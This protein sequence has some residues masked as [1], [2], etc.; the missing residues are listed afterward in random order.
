MSNP[1]R[2]RL[3]GLWE[4]AGMLHPTRGVPVP[5]PEGSLNASV[6]EFFRFFEDGTFLFGRFLA[7]AE[8]SF[9][10]ARRRFVCAGHT[11]TVL[12]GRWR[13]EGS[14]LVEEFPTPGGPPQVRRVELGEVSDE[15]FVVNEHTPLPGFVLR[16][17]YRKVS[18]PAPRPAPLPAD[19]PTRAEDIPFT[20]FRGWLRCLRPAALDDLGRAVL[21]AAFP[22]FEDLSVEA[23]L[24]QARRLRALGVA[25]PNEE[26][27]A[28]VEE[29]LRLG[30]RVDTRR[31]RR[32]AGGDGQLPR[33]CYYSVCKDESGDD[34]GT[35]CRELFEVTVHGPGGT[36]GVQTEEGPN[37]GR[38]VPEP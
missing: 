2:A 34:G 7:G 38:G 32:Y 10:E 6:R 27:Y 28:K 5:W 13:L 33:G 31:H 23:A 36:T 1:P 29:A 12:G 30:A 15:R 9:D 16:V 11:D 22:M 4:Q 20:T 21:K 8:V 17:V 18:H 24:E 26:V 25:I 35:L 14:C 3:V 19:T 37:D